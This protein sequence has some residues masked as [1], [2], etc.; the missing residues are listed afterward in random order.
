MEYIKMNQ[1]RA[2]KIGAF[3]HKD[4]ARRC[5]PGDVIIDVSTGRAIR[6][7][8]DRRA[9]EKRAGSYALRGTY[10]KLAKDCMKSVTID[11]FNDAIYLERSIENMEKKLRNLEDL[12]RKTRMNMQA[13][14]L[15]SS[16]DVVVLFYHRKG[17]EMMDPKEVQKILRRGDR[18]LSFGRRYNHPPSESNES[19]WVALVEVSGLV[20]ERI[21]SYY[22]KDRWDFKSDKAGSTTRIDQT[23]FE[24][25]DKFGEGVGYILFNH[26]KR[27]AKPIDLDA[28]RDKERA[29]A[30]KKRKADEDLKNVR[31]T[32]EIPTRTKI[33]AYR[34]WLGIQSQ[35][36][37]E[38]LIAKPGG[39]NL[40]VVVRTD[41]CDITP[42]AKQ[43]FASA[44]REGGSF[45]PFMLTK[46]EGPGTEH[47]KSS[48]G[49]LGGYTQ[50]CKTG[51][52]VLGRDC[53]KEV[54][55]DMVLVED[56]ALPKS[57][58]EFVD[59]Q[60]LKTN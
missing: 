60:I 9:F 53:N 6:L 8:A 32:D 48:I 55:A 17:D 38:G 36:K 10:Y 20:T 30:E 18:L 7:P 1:Q 46:H 31:T 57:F 51:E 34:G 49:W 21:Q 25:G 54:L 50:A 29:E 43:A 56:M 45:A 28:V 23:G 37:A 47:G 3:P 12:Q 26:G 2:R 22:T 52:V 24:P 19:L 13:A 11:Y 40:G 39:D 35:P 4:L 42:D 58:V 27:L 41:C 14:A 5:K 59:E 44:G 33:F 15:G 16:K